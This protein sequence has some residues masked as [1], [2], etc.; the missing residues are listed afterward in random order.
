MTSRI[1]WTYLVDIYVA[2]ARLRYIL[3]AVAVGRSSAEQFVMTSKPA[4]PVVGCLHR[5]ISRLEAE[6]LLLS[7]KQDGSY[8][9]R[10]SETVSGAYTLCILYVL[11]LIMYFNHTLH[12]VL[13]S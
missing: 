13:S 7:A 1:V 5:G 11:V 6:Q 4:A 3:S 2:G 8:L 10:E 9:I 12:I